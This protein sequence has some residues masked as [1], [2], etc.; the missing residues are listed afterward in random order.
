MLDKLKELGL[1]EETANKVSGLFSE[2]M[3][4]YEE[5]LNNLKSQI[6]K[7]SQQPEQTQQGYQSPD[8]YNQLVQYYLTQAQLQKQNQP[9]HT[10][11]EELQWEQY[12]ADETYGPV[13]KYTK[14]AIENYKKEIEALRN[15]LANIYQSY[16]SDRIALTDYINNLEVQRLHRERYSKDKEKYKYL[17]DLDHKKLAEELRR[18]AQ[19]KNIGSWDGAYEAYLSRHLDS[20]V[21]NYQKDIKAQ[22]AQ[23]ANLPPATEIVG[24]ETPTAGGEAKQGLDYDSAWKQ[25]ER[26]LATAWPK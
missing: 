20:L 16:V 8:Y 5:E 24:S 18:I 1:D 7:F 17:P 19:E 11:R 26:E 25:L 23:K 6:E 21:D 13:F 14:Q 2:N 3:K 9:Q 15:Y 22:E 12:Y 4:K 10:P